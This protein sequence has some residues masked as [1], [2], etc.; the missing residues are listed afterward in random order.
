MPDTPATDVI[1]RVDALLKESRRRY[2]DALATAGRLRE[3]QHGRQLSWPSWCWPPMAGFHAYLTGKGVFPA[4]ELGR[5]TALTLWRLGR[6]VYVP[7]T[8]VADN[9]A[10]TLHATTSG[11]AAAWDRAVLLRVQDWARLPEWCC[12]LSFPSGFERREDVD[13][14]LAPAG[15]FVH[16]EHDHNTGRPEL[17]LLL[18]IDGTWDN[19]IPIPVYLDRPTLGAALAD[20]GAVTQAVQAGHIGADVR[21]LAG[22]TRTD[23]VSGLIAWNVLPLAL[24]LIDPDARFAGPTSPGTVPAP[25]QRHAGGLWKPAPAT[26]QWNIT[27]RSPGP[28]L[29]LVPTM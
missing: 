22:P 19:L 23:A 3:S 6:G 11:G 26:T 4:L 28:H 29:K 18:D 25:A 8:E 15:V 17:R 16:L 24:S 5:V 21:S 7:D 12:Y 14:V 1:G 10:G 9:A 13:A 27:Y 2:P 20:A